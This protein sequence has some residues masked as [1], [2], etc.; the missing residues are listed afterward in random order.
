MLV[1]EIFPPNASSDSE[2]DDPELSTG[3]AKSLIASDWTSFARLKYF[4]LYTSTSATRSPFVSAQS[5]K[6]IAM[7]LPPSVLEACIFS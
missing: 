2:E 6:R 5:A 1:D 4:E 7:V 3:L